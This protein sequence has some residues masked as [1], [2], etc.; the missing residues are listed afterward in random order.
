MA[1]FDVFNGDADGLCALVQLRL[2]EP[3][4]ATQIS[5]VKRD[6]QL[7][8][9]VAAA[10]GD[11]VTVL[12]IS[13][14][15]N[16]GALQRLLADGA[17]LAY[18]DH[19]FAGEIPA[20]AALHAVIDCSPAVC[21]SLLVDR[22]LRGAHGLWAI[23]GAF[24]DNLPEIAAPLAARRG[25][26]AAA[27]AQLRE[28]GEALNYNAYGESLADL[29]YAP[30]E[31]AR[32]LLEAGDPFAFMAGGRHFAVLREGLLED[33]ALARGI[34]PLAV[35][36]AS[37]AYLLPDAAWARRV[38]GM[39]ANELALAHPGR[40]HAILT[41]H[42][43][44]GY[45]VSVRAPK[46]RPAGAETLCRQFPTGGGRAAAAG[47]NRLDEASLAPFLDRLAHHFAADC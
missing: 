37:A 18:F 1:F 29:R 10:A 21:T 15:S 20:H 13:L 42:S 31:L 9:R 4:P 45:M 47:I 44:G 7:L 24:G 38:S 40:A 17:Q 32:L 39:F 16:R 36:P 11:T 19:H 25:V 35:T 8:E 2:A 3:R 43:A 6:I 28:L 27:S 23:A 30:D 26:T 46:A 34:A 41:G 5:G 33:L 14:D 22:Q 12:D